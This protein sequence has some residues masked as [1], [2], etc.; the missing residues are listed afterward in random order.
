MQKREC[1]GYGRF[2][3]CGYLYSYLISIVQILK[4]LK[5]AVEKGRRYIRFERNWGQRAG[6]PAFWS[7]FWQP[8]LVSFWIVSST[9]PWYIEPVVSILCRTVDC[10]KCVSSRPNKSARQQDLQSPTKSRLEVRRRSYT[11]Y[12]I[13]NW[14]S[15]RTEP[16]SHHKLSQ[17]ATMNWASE[18]S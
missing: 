11:Y 17:W 12:A 2:M 8:W 1:L 15:E 4:K 14:A 10:R 13:I 3:L 18:P 9:L 5:Y 6:A 16:V 7:K